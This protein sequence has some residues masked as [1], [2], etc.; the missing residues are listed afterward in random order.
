VKSPHVVL[1]A[2]GAS[3]LSAAPV[4]AQMLGVVAVFVGIITAAA[5]SFAMHRLNCAA[6]PWRRPDGS[7]TT[8]CEYY[9]TH[10]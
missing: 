5:L 10:D 8:M 1:L 4:R 2:L 3:L 6:Y 7:Y 9:R